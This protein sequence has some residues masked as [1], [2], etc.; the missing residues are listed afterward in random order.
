MA[1]KIKA[2]TFQIKWNLTD[3]EGRKFK[4]MT[5]RISIAGSVLI[6]GNHPSQLIQFLINGIDA[7]I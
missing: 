4:A 2:I 7:I 6:Y 1:K 5:V 3:E